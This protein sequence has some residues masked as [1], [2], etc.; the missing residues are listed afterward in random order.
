MQ[1]VT[2]DIQGMTCSSCQAHVE[3]A[4]A[5]IEGVKQVNVNFSIDI[6]NHDVDTYHCQCNYYSNHICAHTVACILEFYR[7]KRY[8]KQAI[9]NIEKKK[10]EAK[11]KKLLSAKLR[12]AHGHRMRERWWNIAPALPSIEPRSKA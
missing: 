3:K 10:K 9:E 5:K 8:E 11:K 4:V 7:D 1:K 12:F 6:L 2:F